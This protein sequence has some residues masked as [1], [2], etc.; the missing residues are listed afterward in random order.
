MAI[1]VL[2]LMLVNVAAG[3]WLGQRYLAGSVPEAVELA[4]VDEEPQPTTKWGRIMASLH[5]IPAAL[6]AKLPRRAAAA[7]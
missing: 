5:R 3:Y 6:L 4:E 1:F 7:E 2:I